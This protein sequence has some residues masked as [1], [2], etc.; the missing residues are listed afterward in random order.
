VKF[1]KKPVVIEAYQ[2]PLD[3]DHTTVLPPAWLLKAVIDEVIIADLA[4]GCIHIKTLEGEMVGNP[5]DWIIKGVKNELYP[6]KPDIFAASYEVDG[7][8]DAKG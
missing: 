7:D 5:G 4:T 3:R 8:C 2:I 6:C 1:R